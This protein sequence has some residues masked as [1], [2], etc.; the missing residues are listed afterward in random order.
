M[1]A[2]GKLPDGYIINNPDS[3]GREAA[4]R[5]ANHASKKLIDEFG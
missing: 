2:A 1:M 5:I 4:R 3:F